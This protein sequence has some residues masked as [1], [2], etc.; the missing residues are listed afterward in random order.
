MLIMSCTPDFSDARYRRPIQI[1]HTWKRR[2]V[3][4]FKTD[5]YRNPVIKKDIRREMLKPKKINLDKW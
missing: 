4:V 3:P 1:G 2:R 5:K